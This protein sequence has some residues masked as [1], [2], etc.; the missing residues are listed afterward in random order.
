MLSR[1]SDRLDCRDYYK[2]VWN[3]MWGSK[4][5]QN[6]LFFWECFCIFVRYSSMQPIF[7]VLSYCYSLYVSLSLLNIDQRWWSCVISWG[8]WQPNKKNLLHT[9]HKEW[10]TPQRFVC[11]LILI[12]VLFVYLIVYL[13]VCSDEENVCECKERLLSWDQAT[14][15]QY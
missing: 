6:S 10:Q 4:W 13:I 8:I 9:Q 11:K 14:G 1:T 12:C 7:F 3:D 5:W 15:D 2:E